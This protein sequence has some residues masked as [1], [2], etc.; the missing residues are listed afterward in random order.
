M[1]TTCPECELQISSKALVCPHCGFPLKKD[2]RV[3]P[4][5]ANKRRRLPNG[6]GQISEIK[7]RNLRKPFRVLVTIDKTSEG[8]PICKP[9]QPQ[10]YFE[11]YNEAYLALVEYNKNPYSLD[12]DITMDKL[13]QMWLADYKTHVGDKMVEKTECC[14]RYLRK[15]HNLKL[16]QMRVHQLKLAIDEATTYKS[17]DE[18]ELPRSAKG[19]IKSLLNLMYDYAVQNELV[20]QNY[21]RAFSLSRIDQEETSR[22]DKSH[23]PYTD[24]EVALIWK[25]LEKYPYLDI[26]L[27]QFYSG[28]RP[29]E[30]L[31]MRVTDIDL[32]NKTFHG[33]SKTISGKNRV[34]PIHSKIFHFVERYY[35]E[36]VLSGCKYMFPSDTQPGK[37]YTYDRYYV[38]FNEARDALGLNKNHRPHDGRV[39]FATMAKKSEVDQYALKKIL[40][41]Y[42]D[43]ITEKYYIKPDMDWLRTEIE[44]IK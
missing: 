34:V 11:T 43:D 36:A 18:I 19:R 1:L 10:S 9:L 28:W 41:H 37:P 20:N 42:I 6:F 39:Q 23:I 13:Y 31:S 8:R 21:A 32:D 30:L 15:I 4:R 5:K 26:T 35:N 17:G 14:W 22:V 24:A 44:K 29:N 40:G 3:Y 25:S 27:I 33:G 12:S 38:R 2:A 16:Q 7:G